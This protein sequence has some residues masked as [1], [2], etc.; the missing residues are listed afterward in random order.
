[1]TAGER[2]DSKVSSIVSVYKALTVCFVR[3]SLRLQGLQAR[4]SFGPIKI[5]FCTQVAF[6]PMSPRGITTNM[7]QDRRQLA[8]L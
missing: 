5:S 4:Y 7:C 1:M 3:P 6:V 2:N 8:S